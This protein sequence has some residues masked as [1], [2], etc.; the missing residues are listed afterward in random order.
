MDTGAQQDVPDTSTDASGAGTAGNAGA[1]NKS[2]DIDKGKGPEVPEI[3]T[4]PAS[5][6]LG[7]A[8]PAAPEK[9]ASKTSAPEKT[10]SALAKTGTP[11][12]SPAP[13]PAKTAPTFKMTQI[14]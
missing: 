1:S 12:T 10:T 4:E 9:S 6:A 13:A 11:I 5:T 7:Q 8:T 14:V 2:A 3:R